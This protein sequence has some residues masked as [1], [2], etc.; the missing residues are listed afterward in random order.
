MHALP[1]PHVHRGAP[2]TVIAALLAVALT[3]LLAAGLN[4]LATTPTS[5][6]AH[7][8]PVAASPSVTSH[9]WALNPFGRLLGAP[10]STPL[11]T[12]QP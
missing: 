5:F 8:T 1:R 3:L 11:T 4:D 10:V 7:G 6:T 12:V 9:G 2:V